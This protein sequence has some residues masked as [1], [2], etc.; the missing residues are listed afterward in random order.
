[1]G[2][3][4][5]EGRC[6]L[7]PGCWSLSQLAIN[8]SGLFA[9]PSPTPLPHH[10]WGPA[11][12]QASPLACPFLVLPDCPPTWPGVLASPWPLSSEQSSSAGPGTCPWLLPSWTRPCHSG[13]LGP[14]GLAVMTPP[15]PGSPRLCLSLPP[16]LASLRLNKHPHSLP[17][18]WCS[19]RVPLAGPFWVPPRWGAAPSCVQGSEAAAPA[20]PPFPAEATS[21]QAGVWQQLGLFAPDLPS[22]HP[23]GQWC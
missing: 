22:A 2:P 10:L 16:A 1:M 19:A 15:P 18:S 21:G 23:S 8:T 11:L 17:C 20:A 14:S 13:C 5:A 4:P 9:P 6:L 7:R 3:E 12:V